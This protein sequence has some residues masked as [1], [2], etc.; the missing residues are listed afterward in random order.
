MMSGNMAAAG[1]CLGLLV[2]PATAQTPS[3]AAAQY[4]FQ[5]CIEK[6]ASRLDDHLS[7][8]ATIA[9]G[10]RSACDVELE[11]ALGAYELDAMSHGMSMDAFEKEKDELRAVADRQAIEAVLDE[12]A[13]AR[14]NSN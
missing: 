10:V 3:P 13:A 14:K 11:N 6:A 2:L 9:K 5:I 7:D 8:A 12:R 1:L 4:V